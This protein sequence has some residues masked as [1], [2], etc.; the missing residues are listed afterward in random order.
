MPDLT[1]TCMESLNLSRNIY[2]D[3]NSCK[4]IDKILI[5]TKISLFVH[6]FSVFVFN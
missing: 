2:G 5:T 3:K 4:Q 1:V 6:I